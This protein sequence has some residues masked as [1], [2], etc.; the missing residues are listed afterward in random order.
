MQRKY[1]SYTEQMEQENRARSEKIYLA[2]KNKQAASD[3]AAKKAARFAKI[4]S[5]ISL[6]LSFAA[7]VLS[8]LFGMGFLP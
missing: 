2:A 5:L 3:A 4:V 7:L 6:A 1:T 8:F